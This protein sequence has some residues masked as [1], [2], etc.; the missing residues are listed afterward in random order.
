MSMI[1]NLMQETF[2][3]WSRNNSASDILSEVDLNVMRVGK[4][5]RLMIDGV[6]HPVGAIDEDAIASAGF[7][8]IS[9]LGEAAFQLEFAESVI[10]QP[11]WKQQ[12]ATGAQEGSA[13]IET[14]HDAQPR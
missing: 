3:P 12:A 4:I 6:L 1:D 9:L 5:L 2:Q 14:P 10:A 8:A 13:R 7:A 11:G